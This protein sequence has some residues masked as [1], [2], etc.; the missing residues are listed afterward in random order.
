MDNAVKF[1]DAGGTIRLR[2]ESRN[3]D[4]LFSVSDTGVGIEEE[5]LASLFDRYAQARRTRRAGAGLGLAIAKEI[6]EAHGGAIWA[7]STVGVG[8]TFYF[9]LPKA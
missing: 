1:T 7:E 9:T 3:D 6:I 8:S 4:V 5:R 2:V